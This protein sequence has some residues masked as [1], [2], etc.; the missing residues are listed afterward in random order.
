MIIDFDEEGSPL[1]KSDTRPDF[2]LFADTGG[3]ARGLVPGFRSRTAVYDESPG[4]PLERAEGWLLISLK[5]YRT[6]YT[7]RPVTWPNV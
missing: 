3:I 6:A 2:M 4:I 5:R 1:G 7:A